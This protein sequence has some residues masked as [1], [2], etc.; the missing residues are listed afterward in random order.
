MRIA[1]K[2][3]VK[4][5]PSTPQVSLTSCYYPL[6]DHMIYIS[7]GGVVSLSDIICFPFTSY[8]AFML[9]DDFFKELGSAACSLAVVDILL[10][11]LHQLLV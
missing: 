11:V 7:G 5:R 6:G 3:R 4:R 1:W 10:S 2:K 8:I 9:P